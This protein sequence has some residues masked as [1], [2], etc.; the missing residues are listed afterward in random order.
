MSWRFHCCLVS[1]GAPAVMEPVGVC[2]DDSKRPDG[3]S[4]IPWRQGLGLYLFTY[5]L[6]L[7][8]PAGWQ[9]HFSI[10]C[11]KTLGAWGSS[12]HSLVRRIG[13]RVM[14]QTGDNT[15]FQFFIQMIAIDVQQGNAA[16]VIATIPL[17]QDWTEFVSLATV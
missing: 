5:Q 11:V 2:R 17:L 12:A 10:L 3:M 1:G 7:E 15:A 4:L 6:P 14:E 13:S 16:S 9:I 8:V